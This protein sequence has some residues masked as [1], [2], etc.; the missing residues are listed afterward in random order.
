MNKKENKDERRAKQ[1]LQTLNY[2]KVEYEPLGNVTPDFLINNKTAVEVRRLNRNFINSKKKLN[3]EN[4]EIS[5]IKKIKKLLENFKQTPH[6]NSSYISLT[7]SKPIDNEKKINLIRRVKKILKKHTSHIS[8][9]RSYKI[10]D[11]IKIT[12][13]PTDK[14]SNIYVYSGC[15]N[16]FFWIIHE[17]QKT[18]QSAIDEK[19]K[20]IEKNFKL[21]NEWWLILVDSIVHGL[22]SKDFK[23]LQNIQLNKQNFSKVIILSA[24]GEF[25]TLE[26]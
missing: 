23:K 6:S 7:L 9:N 20:K 22:D 13:T 2:L 5:V 3:I 24:K 10:G 1:Y 12:F 18:I 8:K 26:L 16:D 15:N 4:I 19:S 25:K 14:K 21:Y 17:L 11:S